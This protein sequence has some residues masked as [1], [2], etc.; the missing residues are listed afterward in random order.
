MK[1]TQQILAIL[2]LGTLILSGCDQTVTVT[3]KPTDTK[4]PVQEEKPVDTKVETKKDEAVDF[5]T[6]KKIDISKVLASTK[7]A[8]LDL[9]LENKQI[10]DKTAKKDA[11][12]METLWEENEARLL[13][14][15]EAGTIKKAP[16]EGWKLVILASNCDGPCEAPNLYRVAWDEKSGK[17]AMLKKYSS[18][19]A[20]PTGLNALLNSADDKFEIPAYKLPQSLLLADGETALTLVGRDTAGFLK[21]SLPSEGN[22][23]LKW[24]EEELGEKAFS[25]SKLGDL[26]FTKKYAE[27]PD[28][29]STEMITAVV[30]S[31]MIVA[32]LPDGTLSTYKYEPKFMENGSLVFSANDADKNVY[33]YDYG[34]MDRGCG[35][36]AV[37][38]YVTDLDANREL[39]L[40]GKTGGIEI[41]EPKNPILLPEVNVATWRKDPVSYAVSSAYTGYREMFEYMDDLKGKTPPTFEEFVA[42]RPVLYWKDPF[43][44]Y[45]AIIRNENKIPAECGKPVIYLYPEK[46]TKVNVQVGIDEFTKTEPAYG[47]KGWDVIAKPTGELL[48]LAD[49]KNY[50]YLFWEGISDKELPVSRGFVIARADA[51]KFLKESLAKLGLNEQESKDFRDFWVAKMQ[52]NTEPYIFVSFLGTSEF[53]KVAP[54]EISPAPETLIRVFMF[55]RPL[56]QKI[57]VEP[58]YLSAKERKGFTVV[59]WGGTSSAPWQI[60]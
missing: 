15:Y 32:T 1:K 46:T 25:D 4:T 44:R 48:N 53:N 24:F 37:G 6:L 21:G 18:E 12:T 59:E 58:Q 23:D 42:K 13:D 43:G 17:V 45:S 60:Q 41:Y 33:L 36:F 52:A 16:Y 3:T 29:G 30:N 40:L 14:A 22:P 57:G 39:K 49:G 19:Y 50:P 2:A 35:V 28:D 8:M 9:E 11:E 20:Y 38:Y 10:Y 55:Y 26:Y 5:S 34:L 51:D 7:D 31:G 56:A 54:L 47:E 27:K